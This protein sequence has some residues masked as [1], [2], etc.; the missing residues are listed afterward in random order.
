MQST[1]SKITDPNVLFGAICPY[2]KQPTQVSRMWN[3]ECC[4]K[5]YPIPK[6]IPES[7]FRQYVLN[8]PGAEEE[9]NDRME[10]ITHPRI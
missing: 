3:M 10:Y 4:A 2:C 8:V 9:Y 5:K 1:F 6:G 7:L